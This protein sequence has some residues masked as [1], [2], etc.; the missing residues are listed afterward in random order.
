MSLARIDMLELIADVDSR[1]ISIRELGKKI[2]SMDNNLVVEFVHKLKNPLDLHL[3][4]IMDMILDKNSDRINASMIASHT[5]E[6]TYFDIQKIYDKSPKTMP[7]YL[8]LSII[9]CNA[10]KADLRAECISKIINTKEPEQIKD[11]MS[12]IFIKPWIPP[13][14][15]KEVSEQLFKYCDEKENG[16]EE[17][18]PMVYKIDKVKDTIKKLDNHESATWYKF[19]KDTDFAPLL[20]KK[21]FLK[22]DK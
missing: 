3:Y 20:L 22:K 12:T 14:A 6:L 2:K 11:M 13:S 15:V 5:D 18:I 16:Y 21:I 7:I 8:Y 19:T 4:D 1:K 17:L 9:N 10:T